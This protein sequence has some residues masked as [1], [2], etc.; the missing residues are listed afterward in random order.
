[1]Q[2]LLSYRACMKPFPRQILSL[3]GSSLKRGGK[4]FCATEERK[5]AV[6]RHSRCFARATLPAVRRAINKAVVAI[7]FSIHNVSEAELVPALCCSYHEMV[8]QG[9]RDIESVCARV[10]GPGTGKFLIDGVVAAAGDAMELLCAQFASVA[11][12]ERKVPGVTRRV[13]DAITR[14][15]PSASGPSSPLLALLHFVRKYDADLHDFA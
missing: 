13:R 9:T 2:T 12:C 11:V 5:R 15:Q 8:V 14:N 10:S 1:M 3:I 4:R 6:L 7:D